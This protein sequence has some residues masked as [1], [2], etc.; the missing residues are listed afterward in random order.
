MLRRLCRVALA[1]VLALTVGLSTLAACFMGDARPGAQMAC[2]AEGDH[3]CGPAMQ[4]AKCCESSPASSLAGFV[5]VKPAVTLVVAISHVSLSDL[6]LRIW[7]PRAGYVD[8]PLTSASPP[9]FLLGSA[10]RL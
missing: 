9:L 2:C 8:R 5:V 4:P 7:S 10:L 6:A 3:D 1:T